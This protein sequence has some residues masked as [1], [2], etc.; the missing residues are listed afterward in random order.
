M[1]E[2]EHST[3]SD[4]C[5]DL[6]T[7]HPVFRCDH[8]AM[9]D[10]CYFCVQSSGPCHWIWSL[11]RNRRAGQRV[12]QHELHAPVWL[13]LAAAAHGPTRPDV[14]VLHGLPPADAALGRVNLLER[15]DV[16]ISLVVRP[17]IEIGG[18]ETLY[19]DGGY[20]ILD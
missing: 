11:R 16:T 4:R 2:S 20:H 15:S 18:G 12:A 14:V 17:D 10:G 3:F 19:V 1:T 5:A 8:T 13:S 6:V 7:T 9:A